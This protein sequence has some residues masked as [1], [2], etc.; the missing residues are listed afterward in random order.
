MESSQVRPLFTDFSWKCALFLI[1]FADDQDVD[2]SLD[3][4]AI[5]NIRLIQHDKT[6][7]LAYCHSRKYVVVARLDLETNQVTKQLV[8]APNKK[9]LSL[10]SPPFPFPF[11]FLF[12]I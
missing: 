4:V 12:F 5:R 2:L 11:P 6:L 10:L 3:A 9:Y 1:S 7:T 8:T